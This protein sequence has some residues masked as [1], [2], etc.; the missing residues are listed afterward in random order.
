MMVLNWE[1]QNI[2]PEKQFQ[3]YVKF[4]ERKMKGLE[5][6]GMFPQWADLA[7]EYLKL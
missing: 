6:K 2:A 3:D 5:K 4:T 1:L 7:G